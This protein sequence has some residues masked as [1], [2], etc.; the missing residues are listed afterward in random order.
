MSSVYEP[1]GVHGDCHVWQGDE[2]RPVVARRDVPFQ[3]DGRADVVD[4]LHGKYVPIV[5]DCA[6]FV[7]SSAHW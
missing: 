4:E 2:S 6:R 3:S 7:D 5:T 1:D